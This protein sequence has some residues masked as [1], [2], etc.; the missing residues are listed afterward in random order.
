MEARV[1]REPN[2]CAILRSSLL[3][4]VFPTELMAS[5]QLVPTAKGATR[6][7]GLKHFLFHTRR[8]QLL[9]ALCTFR[10]LGALELI[11]GFLSTLS[12][13]RPL[14]LCARLRHLGPFRLTT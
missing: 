5:D 10:L 4:D 13:G 7:R 1:K 8:G 9:L 14:G 2:A 11:P 3:F 6:G 12:T